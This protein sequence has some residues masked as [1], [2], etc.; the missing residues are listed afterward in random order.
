MTITEINSL[1]RYLCDATTTSYAAADL[2]ININAAYERIVGKLIG[3]DGTWQFDDTNFT[4]LPIG[5]DD[6]V[7]GQHDYSFDSSQLEVL[8]VAVKDSSGKFYFLNPVDV[9]DQRSQPLE[10]IYETDG[11]PLYYDKSGA[12]VFLYPAPAAGSVTLSEG[13]KVW[14]QRTASVYTAAE[15]TTGTKQPG[16][17]SP[18]HQILAY[19]A[20]LP[21]C[22]KFKLERVPVY[23][24]KVK[25][26][27][28]ELLAFYARREKDV[29]KSLGM[30]GI[31]Y[32]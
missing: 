22:M 4:N 29:P 3:L 32:Q 13:L 8:R 20:S 10:E 14:F 31:S 2:L 28:T 12:S 26:L 16:F 1:T 17:A 30:A 5:T 7:A 11:A 6:L 25:E 19:E 23:A 21:Y 18:Y 27:E 24:N 9:L 15:V